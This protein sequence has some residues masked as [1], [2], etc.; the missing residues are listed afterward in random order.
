MVDGKWMAPLQSLDRPE[1]H[2]Q[3]HTTVL[4][5]Y[6]GRGLFTW[7]EFPFCVFR[8]YCV[9]PPP[10]HPFHL[11]PAGSLPWFFVG[12]STTHLEQCQ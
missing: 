12:T 7:S 3:V 2:V 1:I 10:K 5:S 8:V 9:C 6:L 4:T 11:S